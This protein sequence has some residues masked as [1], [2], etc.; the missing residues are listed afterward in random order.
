[1][2]KQSWLTVFNENSDFIA[3]MVTVMYNKYRGCTTK[4]GLNADQYGNNSGKVLLA[5]LLE[6]DELVSVASKA[7]KFAY[8]EWDGVRPFKA[9]FRTTFSN[10]VENMA[11]VERRHRLREITLSQ[12]QDVDG[13]STIDAPDE[14]FYEIPS[15]FADFKDFLE[16]LPALHRSFIDAILNCSEVL[17]IT[18]NPK[19][20]DILGALRRYMRKLGISER[21]YY[22][23]SIDIANRLRE[24]AT[25]GPNKIRICP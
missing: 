9:L 14:K 4:E 15:E 19:P 23:V 22:K 6:K 8:R 21:T 11:K 13:E 2:K 17:G 20:K 3:T 18:G 7:F 5:N 10:L 1:M 25:D 16:T 12:F 24:R